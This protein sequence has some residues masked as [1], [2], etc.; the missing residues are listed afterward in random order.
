MQPLKANL[1]WKMKDTR[2]EVKISTYPLL[3]DVLPESTMFPVMTTFPL[4]LPLHPAQVPA[5]QIASLFDAGYHSVPQMMKKVLQLTFHP[6]KAPH[7]HRCLGFYT[8]AMLHAHLYH[9]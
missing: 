5:S 4:T 6:P 7:H 8:A 1:L 3:S 9:V 2:V